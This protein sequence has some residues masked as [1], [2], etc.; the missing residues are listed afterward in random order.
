M[1]KIGLHIANSK[2]AFCFYKHNSREQKEHDNIH[3][4]FSEYNS[5]DLLGFDNSK[6]A[7]QERFNALYDKAKIAFEKTLLENPKCR[8]IKKGKNA[9]K[10]NGFQHF[11]PKKH[12]IKEMIL[13]LPQI[14]IKKGDDPKKIRL[15]YDK[16]AEN[17]AKEICD[18]FKIKAIQFTIHRDEGYLCDKDK[19]TLKCHQ[20]AHLVAFTLDEQTGYQRNKRGQSIKQSFFES[21]GGLRTDFLKR[22]ANCDKRA[23]FNAKNL[24]KAQEIV[25][26]YFGNFENVARQEKT[27]GIKGKRAKIYDRDYRKYKKRKMLESLKYGISKTSDLKAQDKPIIKESSATYNFKNPFKEPNPNTQNK[28][29]EPEIKA[30]KDLLDLYNS[31]MRDKPREPL[32][33]QENDNKKSIKKMR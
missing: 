26:K 5:L 8:M 3:S 4:D 21:A 23:T 9:G 32:K 19:N 28:P 12:A 10:P 14:E 29:R 24:S 11:T 2:G 1:T 33:E 27:F 7:T 15:I 22:K 16:L 18:L 6:K 17:C 20:H 30:N 25:Y 31:V 13:E